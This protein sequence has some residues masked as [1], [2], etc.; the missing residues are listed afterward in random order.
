MLRA[1]RVACSALYHVANPIGAVNR[2]EP[3]RRQVRE[4]GALVGKSG[5]EDGTALRVAAPARAGSCAASPGGFAEDLR[6]FQ[7]RWKPGRERPWAL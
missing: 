6:R 3:A 1:V 4:A 5:T 7:A 2:T